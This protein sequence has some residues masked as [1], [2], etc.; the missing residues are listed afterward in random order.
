MFYNIFTKLIYLG[1]PPSIE[2]PY[3]PYPLYVKNTKNKVVPVLQ[4]YANAKYIG[5]VNLQFNSN[6][7]LININGSPTLL[8]HEIK[9]GKYYN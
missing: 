8:N 1:S 5:K 4:A 6:G 2:K 3:G 9:K 7:D